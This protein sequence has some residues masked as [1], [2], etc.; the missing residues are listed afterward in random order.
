MNTYKYI[1]GIVLGNS[2]V[3]KL[4]IY[5]S[6]DPKCLD[7]FSSNVNCCGPDP[8]FEKMLAKKVAMLETTMENAIGAHPGSLKD[9]LEYTFP[10][11][12][13]DSHPI[14]VQPDYIH[15]EDEEEDQ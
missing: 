7:S 10:L 14:D 1:I 3:L 6:M 8:K 5:V 11:E 2:G 4:P 12:L 13:Y 15:M 9:V